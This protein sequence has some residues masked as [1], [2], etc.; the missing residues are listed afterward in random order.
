MSIQKQQVVTMQSRKAVIATVV[1]NVLEWFDFTVYSFFSVIIAKVFFPTGN[2]LTSYL[3]A[4]ATFGVGFFMRPLGGIVIGSYSDRKGRKAALS[5]TI[6][7]MAAG[8]LIIAITPSY[9]QIGLFAPVLIVLARLLQGFSAGGETGSATAFLTEH[10]PPGRK[11]FYASW[12]Q[13]S[14]GLAVVL[15]SGTGALVSS[16]LT[17]EQLEG[18]GWRVPFLVGCLIAPVGFYIRHRIEEPPVI[19]AAG[20]AKSPLREVLRNHRRGATTVFLLVVLWTVCTYAVLFYIPAYA[21]RV[22]GLANQVGFMAGTVGGLV[23]VFATPVVGYLADRSGFRPWLIGAAV[24]IFTLIYPM[25]LMINQFPGLPSLIVFQVVLGLL[26]SAYVGPILAAFSELLPSHVLSTGLS[27]AYNV[28]VTLF[29]GFATF[30]ITW[31]IAVSGNPLAPAFYI[32]FA[33]AVSFVGAVLYQDRQRV[34]GQHW[35]G[36]YR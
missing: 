7:L 6:L 1:G 25:F 21:S 12:L 18:W 36:V 11:A 23:I 15:G 26:I 20:V 14:I 24:G 32:M 35:E 10:A 28:A 34:G 30:T 8:T 4:L 9:A 22:L 13:S 3:M 17:V 33:A 27:I 16:W 19:H 5:L 2:E 29:G 31:L